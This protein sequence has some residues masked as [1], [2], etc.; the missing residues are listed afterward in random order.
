VN[1]LLLNQVAGLNTDYLP[2]NKNKHGKHRENYHRDY[3]LKNRERLLTKYHGVKKFLAPKNN[4]H[5]LNFK[6]RH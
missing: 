2:P 5:K 3:Y 4:R 6:T 1:S